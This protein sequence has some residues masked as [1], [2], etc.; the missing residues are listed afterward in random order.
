MPF[1]ISLPFNVHHVLFTELNPLFTWSIIIYFLGRSIDCVSPLLPYPLP[2][3]CHG[4]EAGWLNTLQ[5]LIE[6]RLDSMKHVNNK[7]LVVV[8]GIRWGRSVYDF[9]SS[10]KIGCILGSNLLPSSHPPWCT[11]CWPRC[12]VCRG[13]VAVYVPRFLQSLTMLWGL[14]IKGRDPFRLQLLYLK[15]FLFS[16][17]SSC[18]LSFAAQDSS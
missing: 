9:Y 3:P 5:R 1:K 12:S 7:L 4:P 8:C 16:A 13:S 10:N 2:R 6:F 11:S 18:Y 17:C 14:E 15:F